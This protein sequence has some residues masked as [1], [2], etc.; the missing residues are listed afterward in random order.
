M[1]KLVSAV[2]KNKEEDEESL[3]GRN[4]ILKGMFTEGLT[5][6]VTLGQRLEE[7]GGVKRASIWKKNSLSDQCS[8]SGTKPVWWT[9]FYKAPSEP[10]ACHSLPYAVPFPGVAKS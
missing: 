2:E 7:A 1:L 4:C 6:L 3:R 8:P 9:P 10:P 5:E